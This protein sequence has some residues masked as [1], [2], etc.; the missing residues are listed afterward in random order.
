MNFFFNPDGVAIVG[1]TPNPR[2]GGYAIFKNLVAGYKGNIYPVNPIYKEIEG[3]SCYPSVSAVPGHVDLAIVFVP[4]NLVPAAIEDCAAKGVRG[5]MI[6][7]GGFAETGHDGTLLQQS[8]RDI[9]K[10]TG[11]RLWGPNCMGLVDAVRGYIFSFMD[12]RS[13]QQGLLV[14]GNVSLVVQS[15]LLSAGFLVD[16][17]SHRVMGISK[18]C[19][20]GNKIDVNECDLLSYLIQDANTEVIGHYLESFSDGRRFT[21]LCRKSAKPIVVLHGGKSRKGAEA[22]MS[23]TASMAGNHKIISGALAQAGVTEA[24]DFHQMM[25]LC[26]SLSARPRPAG[27]HGRIAVLTFSGGSGI[28]AS[29]FIEEHGLAVAELSP[30]TK[31]AL[32]RLFPDWMPVGNPVDLWPAIEK[33]AG[34]NVDVYSAALSAVLSDPMVDAVFLHA[35]AGHLQLVIS[36]TDIAKQAHTAGKPVFVWLL[37]RQEDALRFNAEALSCGIPVFHEISRAV[38]CLAA[39]FHQQR[40]SEIIKPLTGKEKTIHI[41]N[42]FCD[43][44]E[45]VVGPL[46]EHVSKT[47]LR[48]HGIPAVEEEIISDETAC[49]KIAKRLGFPLVMKGLQKEKVHKTELGLV[50]LNITT[51]EAALQI[52]EALKKKMDPSGQVLA[53]KQVKG[54]IEIIAGLVRDFH[55]GPCVMLGLGGIMA[56]IL[57]DAVFAPAPLTL[58]DALT[59][60]SRLRGQ[61]I[62]EGFRGEPPVNRE[63]LAGILVALGDISLQYPRIREIDINPLILGEKGSMVAV[64][65]TIVLR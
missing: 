51:P 6:E 59:L 18:V 42:E 43:I 13:L 35:F 52:F 12:P 61:K 34:T 16:V 5:V 4:A 47:I 26:R 20:I 32:G 65:A 31:D 45:N 8:L 23:H 39:V 1:A 36:V 44:L 48:L 11:I 49:K 50:H 9:A 37:G 38:E 46:D 30:V 64:D 40:S 41:P 17:M 58:E 57:S 33:H 63:E 21:E 53:Y 24:G 60:M 27:R 54:K 28:V 62:F 15:G 22:A 19:S 25:D 3:I 10:R 56:E 2:K 55:F 14:P 29:D 7:S